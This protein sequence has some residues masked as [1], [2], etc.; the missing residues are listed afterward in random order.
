ML[1]LN[2]AGAKF[3]KLNFEIKQTAM[4]KLCLQFKFFADRQKFTSDEE[5]VELCLV[6]PS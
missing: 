3:I 1:N 6:S 2:V 4:D 5:L